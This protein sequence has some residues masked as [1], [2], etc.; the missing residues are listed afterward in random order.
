ML[1]VV[2]KVTEKWKAEGF[3]SLYRLGM[4]L[5]LGPEPYYEEMKEIAREVR[6]HYDLKT[7][8][9][10]RSDLRR[11]YREEG[12]RIAIYPGRPRG[13]RGMYTRRK[14]RIIVI[15]V[16]GLR[17]DVAVY[18]L[19][20]ELK[21]HFVD[22][23]L[24]SGPERDFGEPDPIEVAAEIFAA[25]LIYPEKDFRSDLERLGIKRGECSVR[26]LLRFKRGTRT[27]LPYRILAERAVSMGFASK[28]VFKGKYWR[29]LEKRHW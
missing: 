11:I 6:N 16:K 25:E 5:T 17:N 1:Q 23:S 9:V 19:A 7:S 29:N 18:T 27:T 26:T 13:L 24:V 12:I 3:K 28:N 2:S 22:S 14:V 10:R 4:L 21:H 20:H 8:C 15:L